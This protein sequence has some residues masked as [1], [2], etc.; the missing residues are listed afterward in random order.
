M[1]E[2]K[3]RGLDSEGAWHYGNLLQSKPFK[4]GRIDCW[5]QPKSIL[6]LGA[7]ST[8]TSSFVKVIEKTV[9]QFIGIKD[10]KGEEVFE[11]DVMSPVHY[12]EVAFGNALV[13]YKKCMFCFEINKPF[14][15]KI[16]PI[17]ESFGHGAKANN[18]FIV[19]GNIHQHP[20]LL[21]NKQ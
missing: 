17:T 6:C 19:I 8:P 10:K 11:G 3:F 15:S 20:E 18:H 2:L 16:K 14:I 5:I 13:G 1:R 7:I 12:Q 21:E 4:D 9:G